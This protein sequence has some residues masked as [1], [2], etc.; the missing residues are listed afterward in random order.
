MPKVITFHYK[1]LI[2]TKRH[3]YVSSHCALYKPRCLELM[4]VVDAP[5]SSNHQLPSSSFTYISESRGRKNGKN[6]VNCWSWETVSS[7]FK[8]V[9]TLVRTSPTRTL[10]GD[11]KPSEALSDGNDSSPINPQRHSNM[12]HRGNR[13]LIR[14]SCNLCWCHARENSAWRC[15]HSSHPQ[16]IRLQLPSGKCKTETDMQDNVSH[17]VSSRVSSE[18]DTLDSSR[19]KPVWKSESL[20]G[21][22]SRINGLR[23]N[24][25]TPCCCCCA[26]SCSPDPPSWP[27]SPDQSSDHHSDASPESQTWDT[28]P[29]SSYH[30]SSSF[31]HSSPSSP[32]ISL[33][34]PFLP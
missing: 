2:I 5:E 14:S 25:W 27:H 18:S 11:T 1:S 20:G 13:S 17:S 26:P 19:N 7:T 28:S 10:T 33:S 9:E 8:N 21:N 15:A 23:I 30:Q 29:D 34:L 6:C 31:H 22:M 4:T 3:K 12:S 32:F 24:D 16:N